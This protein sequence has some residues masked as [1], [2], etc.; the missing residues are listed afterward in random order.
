[1]YY[2]LKGGIIASSIFIHSILFAPI[3]NAKTEPKMDVWTFHK[4]SDKLNNLTFSFAR[5]PMP[6]QS[7]Y[8]NIRLEIICKEN[9][10]QLVAETSNLITSQGRE[11]DFEYQI[12][13]KPPSVI[14]LR[15]FKDNKRRGYSDDQIDRIVREFLSGQSIFIRIHTIINTVLSADIPI[16]GAS[17]PIQQVLAECGTGQDKTAVQKTYSLAEFEQD[18]AKLSPEQQAQALEQIK[19]M[20]AGIR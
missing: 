18:F 10:L 15:T 17:E 4:E 14:K 13:K 2:S 11:F 3:V 7:L 1:M 16:K 9:K 5:S 6:K 12:D 20:I 8:D 19:K